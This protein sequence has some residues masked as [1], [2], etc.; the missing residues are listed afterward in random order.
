MI[1][2]K[3]IERKTRNGIIAFF[4]GLCIAVSAL[5]IDE[6]RGDAQGS[7]G[8]YQVVGALIGYMITAVGGVLV[9]K[10]NKLRKTIQN[11][12]LYSGV[13][14]VGIAALAD[15]IGIAGPSGFDGFQIV[16]IIVGLVILS[17]GIF[18]RPQIV[19]KK[20]SSIQDE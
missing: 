9:M 11:I 5:Y 17:A 15:H 18:V 2:K 16:G 8:L 20:L 14:I 7:I 1:I 13:V 6:I 4:L 3:I 19:S 10:A 12:I